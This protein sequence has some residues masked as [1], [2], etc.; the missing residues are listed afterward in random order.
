MGIW[1]LRLFLLQEYSCRG[2]RDTGFVHAGLGASPLGGSGVGNQGERRSM[3][4]TE[5]ACAIPP[6]SWGRRR[7]TAGT[8]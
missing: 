8:S 3:E 4:L 1:Q 5:E 2:Y 6:K 7:E